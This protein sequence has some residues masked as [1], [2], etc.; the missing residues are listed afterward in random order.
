ML[1]LV[2]ILAVSACQRLAPMPEATASQT[3]LVTHIVG[4]D[5]IGGLIDGQEY[6]VRYI[7]VNTPERDEP[8]YADARLP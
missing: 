3:G 6:R 1:F 8:C 7:G 4:G 2:L 5:T